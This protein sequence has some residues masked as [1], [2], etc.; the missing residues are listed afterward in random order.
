MP[1][2]L[3]RHT[4][5]RFWFEFGQTTISDEWKEFMSYDTCL[6]YM[7]EFKNYLCFVLSLP[8]TNHAPF[9]H[10]TQTLKGADTLSKNAT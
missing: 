2:C 1:I 3:P 5:I 9:V 8:T 10:Y 4:D 7:S 6:R